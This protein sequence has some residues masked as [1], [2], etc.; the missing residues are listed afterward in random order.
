MA[1][2]FS[3][4]VALCA[5]LLTL[6]DAVCQKPAIPGNALVVPLL[7]GVNLTCAGCEGQVTWS[8][9]NQTIENQNDAHLLLKSVNYEDE[10]TYSCHKGGA[11]ICSVQVLV[12]D[13]I[14]KP[15]ISCYLRYPTHNI[16]C[17]WTPTRKLRPHASVTLI[18]WSLRGNHQVRSC[19]YVQPPGKFICSSL[20]HEGDKRRHALSLCVTGRTD[21]RVSN[22]VDKSA[23]DLLQPDPPLNVRVTPLQ[24]QPRRLHVAWS[25]PELWQ[26]DFYKLEYQVQY[27]VANSRHVSNGTTLQTHFVIKDALARR[28]H[29]VMV[30]AK[31]EFHRTWGA[32]SREVAATPW[33]EEEAEPVTLPTFQDL[34]DD[35][36]PITSSEEPDHL[37]YRGEMQLALPEFPLGP[38]PLDE[39]E[40]E[41]ECKGAPRYAGLVAGVALALIFFFFLGILIRY[42]DMKVLKLKGILLRSPLQP[43]QNPTRTQP[44]PTRT[45]PPCATPLMSPRSSPTAVTVTKPKA[46]GA[47]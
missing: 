43:P 37:D 12:K 20:Y 38:A 11:A 9:Q 8:R 35:Y 17:E 19:S 31:E 23:D 29:V 6:T 40:P 30:R 21:H 45:Q 46:S 1:A 15:E 3:C 27:R 44:D 36:G 42:S 41:A 18:L 26:D 13:E 2:R 34:T 33:S 5:G 4:V 24:N 22:T 28:R 25:P 39:K 32:W 10:D 7:M 14:E 47:D 16:T